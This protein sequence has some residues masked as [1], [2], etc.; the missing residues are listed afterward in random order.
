MKTPL[1]VHLALLLVALIY[2]TTYVIAKGVM[3]DHLGPSAFIFIRVT[4]AGILFFILSRIVSKERIRDKRDYL[5]LGIAAFF[6]VAANM[7]LFFNGL[8]HTTELNASV[9]MLNAPVF[10]LIF[11]RMVLKQKVS[12]LQ[13]VGIALST[14]GAVLLLGGRKLSFSGDTLQGDLMVLLNA[15][16]FAFYL[17]YVKRLLVK[18]SALTVIR[19]AFL[20]GWIFVLPFAWNELM[21]ADYAAFAPRIWWAIIYVSF[22]TTFVAYAL[23]A[24]AIKN[25]SPVVA[26]SY[27]YLQPVIATGVSELL[28]NQ[29][30][31][32]EKVIF[33][34]LIFVGVFLVNTYKR[35]N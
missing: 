14:L 31:S 34:L 11:S 27:I 28:G 13:I 15:T 3:P 8:A 26:G 22:G 21:E 19:N 25:A 30:L 33:A 1:K 29:L 2:G 32:V 35:A 7:L 10:V 20:F 6:G 16:S 5:D 23:N 24:W 12:N 4:I 18:Y 17:V 9:L